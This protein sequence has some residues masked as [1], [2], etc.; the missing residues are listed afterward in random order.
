MFKIPQRHREVPIGSPDQEEGGGT[1]RHQEG[2]SFLWANVGS[3]MDSARR[4]LDTPLP[5]LVGC[6]TG[7]VHS[8][9]CPAG[10]GTEAQGGRGGGV[11]APGK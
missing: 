3:P 1:A 8:Q 10:G 4:I 9:D 5:S 7:R 6:R 11:A 2:H